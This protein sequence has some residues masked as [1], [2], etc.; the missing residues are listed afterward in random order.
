[1][2]SLGY[3]AGE[4]GGVSPTE[5]RDRIMF[6]AAAQT[7]CNASPTMHYVEV[8]DFVDR[9]PKRPGTSPR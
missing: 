2:D 1:M 4:L 9:P 7:R 8:F 3:R 6:Y 5:L